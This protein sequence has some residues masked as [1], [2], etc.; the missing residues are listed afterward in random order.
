ML[1]VPNGIQQTPNLCKIDI[2]WQTAVLFQGKK[3]SSTLQMSSCKPLNGSA[4]H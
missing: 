1:L 4:Q 3:R 2:V